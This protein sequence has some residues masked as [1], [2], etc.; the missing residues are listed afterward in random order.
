MYRLDTVLLQKQN[1]G[2]CQVIA[3]ALKTLCDV[4]HHYAQIE[5][6]GLALVWACEK[7]V[8]FVE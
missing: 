3:Y 7:V 5:K 4:E 6:E 8:A 1:D 2:S